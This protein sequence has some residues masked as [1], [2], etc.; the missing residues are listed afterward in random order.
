VF[1]SGF[2]NALVERC[3]TIPTVPWDRCAREGAQQAT[4]ANFRVLSALVSSLLAMAPTLVGAQTPPAQL[5]QHFA[6]GLKNALNELSWMQQ[7]GTPWDYRYQ[8]LNG[9]WTGWNSPTGQFA[10]MYAADSYT[11]GAIPVF[12]WYEAEGQG[13]ANLT[14]T[15]MNQ[16]FSDFV[17]FLQKVSGAYYWDASQNA[18]GENTFATNNQTVTVTG[19]G[20]AN[21]VAYTRTGFSS[22]KWVF[23]V[24]YQ[25][26]DVTAPNYV[27][28]VGLSTGAL[29]TS[30]GSELGYYGTSMAIL[31]N[32]GGLRCDHSTVSGSAAA[33][34]PYTATGTVDVAV[35]ATNDLIWTRLRGGNWNNSSS[36]NPAD[37]DGRRQLCLDEPA[38]A[39]AASSD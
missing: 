17:L 34:I 33:S 18:S 15:V 12:T 37:G 4:A 26:Q 6:I 20:G 2:T 39:N 19:S 31:P 3:K 14:P 16:Y 8:Y 23:S 9:G 22:G 35:D 30:A 11:I 21:L 25:L 28:A 32:G 7:T 1:W 27:G 5:P 36:A 10:S 13:L 29:S 38:R 24:Q